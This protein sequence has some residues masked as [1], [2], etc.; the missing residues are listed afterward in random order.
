MILS[1][2]QVSIW[3]HACYIFKVQSMGCVTRIWVRVQESTVSVVW[4]EQLSSIMC[5]FLNWLL[6]SEHW[7]PLLSFLISRKVFWFSLLIFL[8]LWTKRAACLWEVDEKQLLSVLFF[9]FFGEWNSVKSQLRIWK[10]E[11]FLSLFS[12]YFRICLLQGEN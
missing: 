2:E 4:K 12:I 9:F 7:V 11:E 8:C 6:K 1:S 10:T 3:A 5:R